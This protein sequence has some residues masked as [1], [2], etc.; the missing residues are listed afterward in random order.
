MWKPA[1]KTPPASGKGANKGRKGKAP[2]P[3]QRLPKFI[4]APYVDE[5]GCPFYFRGQDE[6][7]VLKPATTAAAASSHNSE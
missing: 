6:D 4:L 5:A 1:R 7:V 2:D 3:G